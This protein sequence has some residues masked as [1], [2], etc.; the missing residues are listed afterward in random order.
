[1]S[2]QDPPRGSQHKLI[3]LELQPVQRVSGLAS[4]LQTG[5]REARHCVSVG[6]N[7]GLV[8]GPVVSYILYCLAGGRGGRG[9]GEG[10]EKT[11]ASYYTGIRKHHTIPNCSSDLFNELLVSSQSQSGEGGPQQANETRGKR[12]QSQYLMAGRLGNRHLP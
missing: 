8:H 4:S 10:G 11:L 12:N 6:E 2:C 7:V 5:L 9:R 3:K 1:M